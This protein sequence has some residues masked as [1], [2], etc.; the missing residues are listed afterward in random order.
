[1]PSS[2]FHMQMAY[3]I[4]PVERIQCKAISN[5]VLREH[6]DSLR[7]VSFLLVYFFVRRLKLC[8]DINCSLREE[9]P[10]DE[11]SWTLSHIKL[12]RF[13]VKDSGKNF[14]FPWTNLFLVLYS[15]N[16]LSWKLRLFNNTVTYLL[17]SYQYFARIRQDYSETLLSFDVYS[18]FGLFCTDF[19]RFCIQLFCLC[20]HLYIT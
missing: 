2:I 11:L 8:S 17:L 12:E 20:F 14:L 18:R 5:N 4:Y 1:M 13:I 16:F 6:K 3:D 7:C 9:C 10:G 19:K 15:G